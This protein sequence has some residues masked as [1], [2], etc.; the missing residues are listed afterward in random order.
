MDGILDDILLDLFIGTLKDNIQHEVR[1]FK[2]TSLEKGFMV[3]EG[4]PLT[5]IERIMFLPLT[6]LNLQGWNLNKLM[7]EEKKVY[8]LIVTT[9][10][11]RDKIVVI[12]NYFLHRL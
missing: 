4:P 2:P 8:A 12:R 3:L 6:Y 9:S 7:K 11:V 1:L 5:P 10:I